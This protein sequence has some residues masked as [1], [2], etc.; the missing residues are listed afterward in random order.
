LGELRGGAAPS[1][2]RANEVLRIEEVLG[3]AARFAGRAALSGG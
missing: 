1:I 2:D 3:A